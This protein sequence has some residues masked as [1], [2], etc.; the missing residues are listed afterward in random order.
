M[1]EHV[2]DT[3]WLAV[4]IHSAA[5]AEGARDQTSVVGEVLQSTVGNSWI[6]IEDTCTIQDQAAQSG[7]VAVSSAAREVHPPWNSS[8]LQPF[9]QQ[10]LFLSNLLE[11]VSLR[12]EGWGM[13]SCSSSQGGTTHAKNFPRPVFTTSD[14]LSELPYCG[15]GWQ[16]PHSTAESLCCLEWW[17]AGSVRHLHERLVVGPRIRKQHKTRL[18][19]GRAETV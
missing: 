19:E 1:E 2:K 8:L 3:Q 13:T 17:R 7:C 9:Q 6:G 14:P 10:S 12:K 15:T 4:P 18:R 11:A 5:W 16:R